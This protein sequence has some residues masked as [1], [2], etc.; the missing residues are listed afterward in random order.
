MPGQSFQPTVP[1]VGTPFG[2][3]AGSGHHPTTV[4]TPDVYGVPERPK[5]VILVF[6]PSDFLTQIP[7]ANCITLLP[8]HLHSCSWNFSHNYSRNLSFF[9]FGK[10]QASVPNWLREEIIKNKSA[11]TTSSLEHPKEETESIEDEAVDKSLGKADQ[12]DSKSID[13]SKSTEEEDD[14]EVFFAYC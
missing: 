7:L 12:A 9:F 1:S 4:F 3:G 10:S 13:S 6:T 5:K 8:I 14:D 2:I 11:I